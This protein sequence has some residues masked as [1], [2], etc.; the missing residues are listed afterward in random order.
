MAQD[1]SGGAAGGGW[2][3]RAKTHSGLPKP[4]T[5]PCGSLTHLAAPRLLPVRL[6]G[7]WGERRQRS[8]RALPALR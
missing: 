3:V 2:A 7:D 4:I 1:E 8:G 6:R 5:A